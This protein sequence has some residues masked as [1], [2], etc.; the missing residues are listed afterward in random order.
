MSDGPERFRWATT[1]E[2]ADAAGVTDSTVMKWAAKG[3][4]PAYSTVYGG[5]R[6]RSAR[7]PLHAPDQARWVKIRLG[8]GLTF[9]E[10]AE[11][12]AAGEFKRSPSGDL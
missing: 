4:L 6:G 3:V 9:P 2:V 1:K 12:L 7:W 5:A 10:I 11:M 8:Q